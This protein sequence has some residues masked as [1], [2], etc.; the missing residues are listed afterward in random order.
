MAVQAADIKAFLSGGAANTDPY[1]S[2][3]GIISATE[4]NVSDLNNLFK[5]VS[6]DEA[7]A[8]SVKYRAFFLVNTSGSTWYG[9]VMYLDGAPVS[10]SST[11]GLVL[12]DGGAQTIADED[13]EPTGLSAFSS[14]IT[15]ETGISIGDMVAGASQLIWVKRSVAAGATI[16]SDGIGV[17]F[18]GGNAP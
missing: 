12:D 6:E 2:L 8:G 13:T 18:E 11:I 5:Y 3:G 4:I 14:P 7:A 16:E 9:V 15:K 17:V 1:A 10:A